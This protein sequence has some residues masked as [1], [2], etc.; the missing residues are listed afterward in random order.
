MQNLVYWPG[1]LAIAG[2]VA[3]AVVLL[4]FIANIGP[5]M[6]A[7]SFG[8]ASPLT[9]LLFIP[10]LVFVLL[11]Y[12][13]FSVL[14]LVQRSM[15]MV[16]GGIVALLYGIPLYWIVPNSTS[17]CC[18]TTSTPDPLVFGLETV[19]SILGMAGGIGGFFF[20]NMSRTP[21]VP[22]LVPRLLITA[23]PLML[24]AFLSSIADYGSQYL[25]IDIL[26]GLSGPLIVATS[27]I[28][29]VRGTWRPRRVGLLVSL[30]SVLPLITSLFVIANGVSWYTPPYLPGLISLLASALAIALGIQIATIKPKI[31]A[32]TPKSG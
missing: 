17:W 24:V 8:A 18:V 1:L 14:L 31:P 6:D 11:F 25:G 13:I 10:F 30:G 28:A 2:I 29:L 21:G 7:A 20:G 12:T 27:G 26:I 3:P 22:W 15:M 32:P 16:W 19:P 5:Q 4:N 9:V 23:A